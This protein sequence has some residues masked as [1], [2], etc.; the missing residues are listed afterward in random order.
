MCWLT[1]PVSVSLTCVAAA[2]F[3]DIKIDQ[4]VSGGGGGY[5][6]KFKNAATKAVK[7]VVSTF[8]KVKNMVF[9]SKKNQRCH[10]VLEKQDAET[11]LH[12]F[13]WGMFVSWYSLL[14]YNRNK[15][16]TEDNNIFS[17]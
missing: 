12:F 14:L 8:C 17:A 7:E 9:E 10:D 2:F 1:W 11:F 6:Q 16:R 13:S 3:E 4:V 15:I 5:F